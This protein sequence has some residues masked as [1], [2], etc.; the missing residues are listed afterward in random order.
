[1]IPD[2]VNLAQDIHPCFFAQPLHVRYEILRIFLFTGASLKDLKLPIRKQDW[3]NYDTLWNI[4]RKLAIM[5]EKRFP[6]KVGREA[7][8]AANSNFR[9][10]SLGITMTGSL[11]YSAS[12]SSGPLFNFQLEPL[13]LEPTHRLS[14]RFGCDR[15]LEIDIPCFTDRRVPK[16]IQDLGARGKAILVEWLGDSHHLMARM[17]V[18]FYTKPRDRKPKKV[19]H[20]NIEVDLTDRVFFFAIDGNEFLPVLPLKETPELSD[21]IEHRRAWSVESLLNWIRPTWENRD[22]PALKLFARTALA[23]SRNIATVVIERSKIRPKNDIKN[24]AGE[25]MT[26]GAGRIS[27]TLARKVAQQ[28]GL[29]YL[30]SGFQARLGEAKGF[31]S[32]NPQDYGA[33]EWIEVYESQRKWSRK[34]TIDDPDCQDPAH[35]TFEVNKFSGALKPARLNLQLMPILVNQANSKAQMWSTLTKLLEDSLL[36]EIKKERIAMDNPQLFRK[37]V[38]EAH[39]SVSDRVKYGCVSFKAAVPNSLDERMNMLLDAGF[40]PLKLKYLRE[41][42]RL[43]YKRHCDNLKLKLNVTIAK[44]TYAFMVPDFTST[45]EEGEVYLHLSENFPGEDLSFTTGLPLQGVDVLVARMPAHFVSDVQ[46]VKAVAK[47]ELLGLRDVIVFSTKGESLASKLSGGDFDGDLAWICWE[48]SVVTNFE[49][50]KVPKCPDLVKEGFITKDTTT[51][52]ELVK[53]KPDKTTTFLNYGLQFNLEQRLLSI[54]TTYKEDWFYTHDKPNSRDAIWLC[55]LLSDLVDQ[56]KA[57]YTFTEKQWEHF[58]QVAINDRKMTVPRYRSEKE[59]H[60]NAKHIIDHLKHTAIITIDK[61]LTSFHKSLPETTP[62]WDDDLAAF[63]VWAM[64]QAAI[65]HDSE[66]IVILKKL[67]LDLEE[68]KRR[69]AEEGG[70]LFRNID[71]SKPDFGSILIDTFERYQA[72]L[73]AEDTPLT[74]SLLGWSGDPDLS[75]WAMLRASALFDSY[76]YSKANVSNFVWWMA[77]YQLCHLKVKARKKSGTV[78]AITPQMYAMLKPDTTFVKLKLSKDEYLWDASVFEGEGNMGED[79]DDDDDE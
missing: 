74:R 6:D 37:W 64:K 19:D 30:P 53:G 31:W 3:S 8:A 27:Q 65:T 16:V 71:E 13:K 38:R 18:R 58:K 40:E 76:K 52:E 9:Q 34:G 35:R 14:R 39:N 7:W 51:Y 24:K 42:A 69:W 78:V 61:T 33:D 56:A 55:K 11:R 28:L 26:D 22:E 43:V 41:L 4:L 72:I 25:K 60:S 1:L 32:V 48:S 67:K 29:T 54:C 47:T 12:S 79:D 50:A 75:D 20:G 44:S 36:E 5:K 21:N 68:A 77:G 10:G 2:F 73:P 15:F 62:S 49:N 70:A 46:R 23:L 59:T 45:L 66:W 63:S 57:G 17:W